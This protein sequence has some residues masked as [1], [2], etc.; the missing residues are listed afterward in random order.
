MRISLAQPDLVQ[1]GAILADMVA[2]YLDA[3]PPLIAEEK[4]DEHDSVEDRPEPPC[5][6]GVFLHPTIDTDA[7]PLP[8][9]EH[10]ASI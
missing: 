6:T 2:A 3:S 4:A 8:S 10:G 7:G 9:G 5:P 1:A